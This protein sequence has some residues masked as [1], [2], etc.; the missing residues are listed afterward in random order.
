MQSSR[1]NPDEFIRSLVSRAYPSYRG[2]KYRLRVSDAPIN[3]A[4]YWD[5]GSRDYF[6][7]AN[8]ATGEVSSQVPAQSAF[9]KPISGA[10]DVRLPSG[11]VCIEHSIFCG[12][13]IGITIH[14]LP[15]NAARL[16][17]PAEVSPWEQ[18]VRN[19]ESEGLTRSDAQAVVDAE[20]AR[21]AVQS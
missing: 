14:V 13:D 21:K 19:L 6:C 20:D 10:Q 15:E 4:S 12:K 16:L 17:P 11:F 7:F 9:D 5:G 8:L 1:I 2:R 18:R 3:C